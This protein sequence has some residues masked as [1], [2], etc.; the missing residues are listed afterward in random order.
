MSHTI[1][2]GRTRAVVA[3][4][5]TI[6]CAAMWM[7]PAFATESSTAV[8]TETKTLS[9]STTR[10]KEGEG[11]SASTGSADA[12]AALIL[13]ASFS[14]LEEDADGPRIDAAKKATNELV[15][16]LPDTAKMGL[17]TYGA[18]ESNA[19]DNR[20]RGC[21]DIQRLVPVDTIDK[22]EFKSAIDGLTPKG[23]T[24]MGNAL[25]K[26]A[27]ELGNDGERS[28]IL[29]SDGIDTC[30]P[31]E[32]CDVAKE[33]AG[34]GVDLTIHTVGFKADED[35]RAELE[36]I[37][38]AGGGQFLEAADSTSLAESLKFLSQ[39]SVTKYQTAGTHFEFSDTPEDAKWLGEG[40]YQTTVKPDRTSKTDRYFR[41]SVPPRHHGRVVFTP[42]VQGNAMWEDTEVKVEPTEV[43][44]EGDPA[45]G[46]FPG[47]WGETASGGPG[48]GI[49][50]AYA[51]MKRTDEDEMECD[52]SDIL[53]KMQISNSG[54]EVAED[55]PIEVGIFYEP[56]PG[57]EQADDWEDRRVYSAGEY[58]GEMPIENS[59]PVSGGT[60]F[61]DAVEITEGTYSDH[62]VPGEFKFFKIPVTYGQRPVIRAKTPPSVARNAD[63]IAFGVK[64]PLRNGVAGGKLIFFDDPEES[65]PETAN[66]Y[67]WYGS[68]TPYQGDYYVWFGMGWVSEGYGIA[69]VDQPFEFEVLL[70]GEPA[71]GGPD[72]TPTHENGPEP[73]DEPIKFDAADS[74]ATTS[75]SQKES[76]DD[77]EVNATSDEQDGS[78]GLVP[79]LLGG[80]LVLLLI[81]AAVGFVIVRKQRGNWQ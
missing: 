49:G 20:E 12:K 10:V 2:F 3:L 51:S 73:A 79:T 50:S 22:A 17:L 23:Y 71:N 8:S 75:A 39:R 19:P 52:M 9:S 46:E 55:V 32:V 65:D 25:R 35:A 78:F 41:F 72:W 54:D 66:Q 62:I 47:S 13:D 53:V 76:D 34:Q 57:K 16:S 29:V 81:A 61:N 59:Q 7:A 26:A 4:L 40:Q 33:L 63:D 56:I 24:P 11:A 14:M 58:Q 1:R 60:G 6:A 31:P 48:F 18:Q 68:D 42:I 38:E 80:L 30:A 64:D 43:T 5:L 45:C 44:N 74:A 67:V 27:D 37:A 21:K 15:D 70:D 36:C 28:I 77:Q 69:G